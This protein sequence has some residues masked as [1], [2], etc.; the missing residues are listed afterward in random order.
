MAFFR[1]PD[2]FYTKPVE[3]T[4]YKLK[5]GKTPAQFINVRIPEGEGPFPAVFTI[6]GGQW[7]KSYT[8]KQMEYLCEDLKT[9]GV[10]TINLE[11]RRLGHKDG[12]YPGTFHD[13]LDGIHYT[14]ARAEKWKLDTNQIS[15]LGHSSGGHL[16]FCLAG[17]HIENRT[18]GFQPKSLVGM[19]GVYNLATAREKLQGLITE[20][21]GSNPIISPID[22]LPMRTKQMLIVGEKDKLTEQA[23]SYV[24][25]AQ[26]TDPIELEIIDDCT[27]F[28]VID[29]TFEG[30]PTIRQ[31]ILR[32][33]F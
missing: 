17:H 20:F 15:L 29:P 5:Y 31:A 8:H 26:E 33:V 1:M 19:A 10:A 9:H 28:R 12:G 21:F 14:L 7:K 6:H 13:L 11:Y 2:V 27:H 4:H 32:T 16:A 25:K 18:L 3:P 30:W 23:I 22:L 24:E